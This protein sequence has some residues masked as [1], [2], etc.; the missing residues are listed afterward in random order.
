[1]IK[2]H[3]KNNLDSLNTLDSLDS[4]DSGNSVDSVKTEELMEDRKN[5]RVHGQRNIEAIRTSVR[6]FG[7]VSPLVV[8]RRDRR[9]LG[10]NARLMVAREMGLESVP[11]VWVDLEMREADALAIALNRSADLADWDYG[12]LAD[13]IDGIAD[14]PDADALLETT[15]FAPLEIQALTANVDALLNGVSDSGGADKEKKEPREGERTVTI[16]LRVSRSI[17]SGEVVALVAGAVAEQWDE[18]EVGLL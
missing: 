9:V 8:N 3:E 1:M 17:K 2:E 10:G 12:A 14:G 13:L 15:G 16:K 18:E 11:V 7:F 5:A 6:R 4:L